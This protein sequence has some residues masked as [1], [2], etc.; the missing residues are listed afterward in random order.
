MKNKKQLKKIMKL[1][2]IT[3]V[4]ISFLFNIADASIIQETSL[5]PKIEINKSNYLES[6]EYWKNT[7]EYPEKILLTEY[8]K[9]EAEKLKKELEIPEKIEIEPQLVKKYIEK[10]KTNYEEVKT[11]I[12]VAKISEKEKRDIVSKELFEMKPKFV[13]KLE[14]KIKDENEKKN[15]EMQ[16]T[17]YSYLIENNK[18]AEVKI[19]DKKIYEFFKNKNIEN[20]VKQV[21]EIRLLPLVEKTKVKN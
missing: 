8:E 2:L 16:I 13:Q 12:N 6:E 10:S 11:I 3:L 17:K 15:I 20:F 19:D 9:K 7:K 18:K 14:E 5:K 21:I 4:L 1:T